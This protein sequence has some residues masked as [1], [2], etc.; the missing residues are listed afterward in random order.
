MRRPLRRFAAGPLA[1]LLVLLAASAALAAPQFPPLTGRVVDD[2]HI[3]SPQA[4]QKLDG[5]LASLEAQTGNYDLVVLGAENRAIQHRLFFGYD[6][7]RLIR[8]AEV[9]VI[10]VVPNVARLHTVS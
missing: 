2:A 10:V 6:N 9:P 5:D 8:A 1:A 4:A 7:E 3:L